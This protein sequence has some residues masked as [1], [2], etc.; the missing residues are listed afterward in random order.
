MDNC[1]NNYCPF[2]LLSV[3]N[4]SI[5]W[6]LQDINK[7]SYKNLQCFSTVPGT[8]GFIDEHNNLQI[9]FS[10]LNDGTYNIKLVENNDVINFGKVGDIFVF[11]K[12]KNIYTN[13]NNNNILII[14]SYCNTSI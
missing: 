10:S 3:P 1:S 13:I 5:K 9:Y 8:F 2:T 6:L 12:N 4:I 14:P 7:K 11:D